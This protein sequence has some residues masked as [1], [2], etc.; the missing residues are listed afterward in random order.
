LRW[1]GGGSVNRKRER[2]G[3]YDGGVEEEEM[4]RVEGRLVPREMLPAARRGS[5]RLVRGCG[6]VQGAKGERQVARVEER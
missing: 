3:E 1:S 6:S 2:E 4:G 5:G